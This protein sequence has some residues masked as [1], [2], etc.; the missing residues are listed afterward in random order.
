MSEED[1]AAGVAEDYKDALEGLTSNARVE[2]SNLTLIAREN[3]ESAHAIAEVLVDHIK[4][5]HPPRKLPALY[6]LDSIVKNVGTP[7]TLFFGRKLYQTFMEAYASVDNATRRKMD[8]MLKTWK[9]P[10]PGSLDTRPV[11]PPEVVRPIENALIKARTSALQAQQEQMR[12]QHHLLGGRGRPPPPMMPQG[13]PYRETPTPP[14]ARG[15]NGYGQPYLPPNV[16]GP[17]NPQGQTYP[18]PQ[19]HQGMPI[20]SHSM[21]HAP[22]SA[23]AQLP[24][25]PPGQSPTPDVISIE[26]LNNDVSQLIAA[27]RAEIARNPYDPSQQPKLDALLALQ[28]LL[29]MGNL[30]KDQLVAVK[31]RIDE[32]SVRA[33]GAAAAAAAA[34]P[35]TTYTPPIAV[36]L[37]AP[38]PPASAPPPATAGTP[39][40][41]DALLGQGALAALLARTPQP[42]VGVPPLPFVPPVATPP[43]SLAALR[44]P[45]PQA[46]PA[47][48]PPTDASAL[49]AALRSK[50]ILS[51]GALPPVVAPTPVS[52]APGLPSVI[53]PPV[54]PAHVEIMGDIQLTTSSLKQPRLYLVNTLYDDLGK[55]CTQCGRR[56]RNDE[57]GR[58]AKTAHMDWHFRVAARIAEAEKKGQHRSYYVDVRDWV[59]SREAVDMDGHAAQSQQSQQQQQNQQQHQ[60]QD[61]GPHA[62]GSRGRGAGGAGAGGKRWIPVPD[63]GS[64]V[65]SVCPIC[66]ERFELKWLDEAQEWV[67]MD[68]VRPGG[69]DRV[70]HAS[71]HSEVT[72]RGAT[73]T[74]PVGM[75]LGKRKAE[76]AYAGRKIK[77][78]DDLAY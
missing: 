78:Y 48:P 17:E 27:T 71:C 68:A 62:A 63:A 15:P 23:P 52:H 77:K 37:I 64:N 29:Q 13:M 12:N 57:A 73:P 55:P 65:N 58:A 70:F 5:I 31:S 9:E 14:G 22:P 66:Q 36:P 46:P 49:L 76:D 75:V 54:V 30:P 72:G 32:L 45:P 42:P 3:T 26:A 8:E 6:L 21:P 16:R 10:V 53:A 43:A 11:F 56:F 67:W 7:Y 35:P 18:T 44:S 1:H 59:G 24:F 50:G 20:L 61:Q 39:L 33:R 74:P 38:P 69:G 4:Q 40:S 19:P 60:Y 47:I 51:G 41:L 25:V 2:I 34:P 28:P